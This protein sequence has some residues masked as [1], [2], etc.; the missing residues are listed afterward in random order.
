MRVIVRFI[1][2][3]CSA[4][5]VLLG[6]PMAWAQSATLQ[7]SQGPVYQG[8]AVEVHVVAEGFD[9][10]PTPEIRFDAPPGGR[11]DFVGVSPSVRSKISIVNG[12]VTRSK[13]VHF[14]FRYRFVP[15]RSGVAMLG[16]FQLSQAGKVVSTGKA[17]VQVRALSKNDRIKVK[18]SWPEEAVY[19]GQRVLVKLEWAFEVELKDRM[20][21]Y[22]L[23][24]PVFDRRDLFRYVDD[25]P[26][27]GNTELVVQT[28]E[29]NLSLRATISDR[30]LNGRKYRVV[31]AERVLIPREP[32]E[33]EFD[34]ATVVVDE[35]VRWRRDLFGQRT[36]QSVRKVAGIG[37]PRKL[38]VRDVPREGR[39]DSYAG[40]IGRGFSIEASTNRS[41]VQSGDPIELTLI[42]RGDGNLESLGLPNLTTPEGLS[43][44]L[45]R[46]SS[47]P[48]A[49]VTEEGSKT[50]KVPVRVLDASVRE[51][52]PLAYSY[53]DT[54][55]R[56]YVTVHSRPIA[57]SVSRGQVVTADDVV[58]GRPEDDP[59]AKRE[60]PPPGAGS[61]D[62]QSGEAR[63]GDARSA[64][65]R[66][67]LSGANLSIVRDPDLLL[68][69]YSQGGGQ[70]LLLC[71]LY[72]LPLVAIP[73]AVWVRRRADLDPRTVRRRK[74]FRAERA[75]IDAAA[76]KSS[77]EA[78]ANFADALRTMLKAA[79]EARPPG[80][81]A[82]LAECDAV[83][84]AP[85]GEG[86]ATLDPELHQ[87]AVAL[88]QSIQEGAEA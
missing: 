86:R 75:R 41:V 69:R 26:K 45:F 50:F 54:D 28:R 20:Q 8:E 43:P 11:L 30:T 84:Y 61:A 57:L 60:S 14:T 58:S 16:P 23:D 49:G 13:Q 71:A 3:L 44:S 67:V 17:N 5:F 7:L 55:K 27:Q 22:R 87:R 68:E 73:G 48:V 53:F 62:D 59:G 83:V 78:M 65:G 40:A 2:L 72:G 31:N 29:G 24:V 4:A 25:P 38:V 34:A 82:F 66:L 46:V 33:F 70:T 35:V 15:S 85:A 36:P 56:E 52:P 1:W 39:P 21:S 42:L 47:G 10:S 18:L 19:P 88:A 64:S 51:V 63:Y 9:E 6:V 74:L 79:P 80:F 76:G 81:D 77:A 32:G 37:D 12:Q